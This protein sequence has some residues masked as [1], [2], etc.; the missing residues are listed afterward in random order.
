M[1]H[2]LV[3]HIQILA[4]T[5]R[6]HLEAPGIAV[7]DAVGEQHVANAERIEQCLHNGQRS[8]ILPLGDLKRSTTVVTLPAIEVLPAWLP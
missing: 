5:A 4:S 3:K 1:A 6:G 7:V 8:A 2:R